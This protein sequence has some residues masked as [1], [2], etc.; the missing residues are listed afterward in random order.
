MDE[1]PEYNFYN[2]RRHVM[3]GREVERRGEEKEMGKEDEKDTIG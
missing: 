3:E 1:Y 2:S